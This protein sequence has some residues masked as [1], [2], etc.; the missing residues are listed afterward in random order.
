[1]DTTR[2]ALNAIVDGL[3]DIF[4]SAT[5]IADRLKIDLAE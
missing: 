2:A 5:R 3:G 4:I 1:V